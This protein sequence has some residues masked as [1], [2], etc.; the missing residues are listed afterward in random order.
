MHLHLLALEDRMLI[1]GDTTSIINKMIT[2]LI[3]TRHT[4]LRLRDMSA[5]TTRCCYQLITP[6]S[7]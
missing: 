3:M 4:M 7:P 5:T 6:H 2:W 1:G